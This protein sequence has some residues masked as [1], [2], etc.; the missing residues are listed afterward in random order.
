MTQSLSIYIVAGV[1]TPIGDTST[2]GTQAG[3]V[4][5]TEPAVET[6]GSVEEGTL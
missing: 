2:Q 6:G 4:A 3:G 1:Q 5:E